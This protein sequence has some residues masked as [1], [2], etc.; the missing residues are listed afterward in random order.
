[1]NDQTNYIIVKAMQMLISK[2]KAIQDYMLLKWA[3]DWIEENQWKK[4]FIW[5]NLRIDHNVMR[6]DLLKSKTE[7]EIYKYACDEYAEI[8]SLLFN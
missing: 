6:Q 2:S 7:E 3:N 1:M 5:K 8:T 4:D